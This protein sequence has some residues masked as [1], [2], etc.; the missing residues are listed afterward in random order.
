MV[1]CSYFDFLMIFFAFYIMQK[2]DNYPCYSTDDQDPE[3]EMAKL[4]R[5]IDQKDVE[6]KEL[7]NWLQFEGGDY[8]SMYQ[9]LQVENKEIKGIYEQLYQVKR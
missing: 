4:H 9:D 8:S 7:Q 6:I 3:L 1:I 2:T 5:L